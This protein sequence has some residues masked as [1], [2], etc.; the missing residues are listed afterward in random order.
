MTMG[1]LGKATVEVRHIYFLN[2][3]LDNFYKHIV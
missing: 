2:L 3:H 1:N